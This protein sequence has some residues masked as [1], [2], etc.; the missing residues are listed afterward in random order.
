MSSDKQHL[1]GAYYGP[2]IPPQKSYHRHGRSRDCDCCGCLCGCLFSLI[3]KV[4]LTILLTVCLAA[5]VLWL[6]FRPN[7]I[8]FHVT[9][10]QLTQFDLNTTTNLL[11]YDL[12]LNLTIR[13]PNKHIGIYYDRLEARAFYEGQ[14][15]ASQPLTRF[16]QRKKNTTVLAIP[17]KG[18][19]MVVLNGDKRL[20]AYESDKSSGTY[21]ID[22]KLY[23]R[24]R[25]KLRGIKTPRFRPKI[26]CDLKVPLDSSGKASGTFETEKCGL[27]W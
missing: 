18:E 22:M 24:V 5:F 23:L 6:I 14:R 17:F 3:F 16:Y 2:S 26:E 20:S 4:L 13:N 12:S 11:R 19:N 1:N 21:D 10:A 8:K 27:D 9:D 15:F 7:R 25:F